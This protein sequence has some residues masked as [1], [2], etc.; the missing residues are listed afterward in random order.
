MERVDAGPVPVE[1]KTLTPL[2]VSAG[3][4]ARMLCIGE[5]NLWSLQNRGEIPSVR[6][7]RRRMYD[8]RDLSAFIDRCK[9]PET[10]A[11]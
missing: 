5:R 10:L 11:V 2:L 3:D 6:I 9:I 4:A 8:P 1:S 7:G